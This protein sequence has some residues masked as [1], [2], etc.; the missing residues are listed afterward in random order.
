MSYKKYIKPITDRVLAGMFLFAFLPLWLLVVFAAFVFIGSPVFFRQQRVG[1]NE[2]IF[3]LYKIRTMSNDLSK[4]E[5]ER[6][7]AI[8]RFLRASG[9]D[10]WPQLYNV[11]IGDMSFVG[12]RPLLPEYLERY[13]KDQRRRH[14][15]KPGITGLAQVNGRNN[16][17]WNEKFQL[18]VSYVEN[19]SFKL[20]VKILVLTIRSIL[21][22]KGSDPSEPFLG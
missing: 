22:K 11:L 20:D 17:G 13:S 9:L 4:P 21:T 7:G 16:I 19:Q 6:V 1:L 18:D 3:T 2:R 10:E 15:V 5:S 14:E 12:P 8:G